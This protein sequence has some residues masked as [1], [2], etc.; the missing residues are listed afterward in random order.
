MQDDPL[1]NQD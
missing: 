1:S